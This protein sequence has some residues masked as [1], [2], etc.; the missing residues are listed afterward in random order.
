MIEEILA[1]VERV[2]RE[3]RRTFTCPS[4]YRVCTIDVP[5]TTPAPVYCHD[6]ASEGIWR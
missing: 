2:L 4:C 5:I 1:E 3:V 6:C